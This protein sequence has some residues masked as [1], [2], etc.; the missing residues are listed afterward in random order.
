MI[1]NFKK[2]DTIT[3]LTRTN[4]SDYLKEGLVTPVPPFILKPGGLGVNATDSQW[5]F[6][7]DE[8]VDV[9]AKFYIRD[10]HPYIYSGILGGRPRNIVR[11]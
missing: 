9:D 6:T 1:K 5:E 2:G 8:D 4:G 11:R 10:S 7:D 3:L